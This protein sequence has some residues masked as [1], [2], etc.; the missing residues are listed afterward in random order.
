M[1]FQEKS[2]ERAN[3]PSFTDRWRPSRDLLSPRLTGSARGRRHAAR[4]RPASRQLVRT[5]PRDLLRPGGCRAAAATPPPP[6][7]APR[8]PAAAGRQKR[9]WEPGPGGSRAPH[10]A[11][12]TARLGLP[13]RGKSPATCFGRGTLGSAARSQAQPPRSALRPPHHGP[14]STGPRLDP[15]PSRGQWKVL[16]CPSQALPGF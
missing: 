6:P 7:P 3:L 15:R 11:A 5:W 9:A 2:T 4:G 12:W 10:G 13:T 16:R 1:P 14:G 8:P